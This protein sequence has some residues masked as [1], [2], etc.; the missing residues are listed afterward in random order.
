MRVCATEAYRPARL[1]WGRTREGPEIHSSLHLE[2]HFRS[3]QWGRTREGPEIGSR[4]QK[5]RSCKSFNGAG[6]VRVRR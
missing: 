1:Q 2:Y 6:P 3:L 5:N 4:C